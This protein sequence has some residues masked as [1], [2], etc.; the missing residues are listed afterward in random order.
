MAYIPKD[1]KWYLAEV[2]LEHLVEDDPRNVIHVNT[3]LVEASSPDDAYSKAITLGHSSE[4]DYL[5]PEGKEVKIRFRGLR[6]LNVIHDELEHG[7]ELIYEEKVGVPESKIK[8]WVKSKDQM[9][10][11][12]PIEW[13]IDIPNYLSATVMKQL[14]D[15]LA[16]QDEPPAE[17]EHG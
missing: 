12:L 10:V 3:I 8:Q 4:A 11:F 1:A 5:N 6:D 14:E 13:K 2:V 17:E 7:A 16:A 9:D 15:R